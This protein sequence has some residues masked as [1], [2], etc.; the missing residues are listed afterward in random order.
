MPKFYLVTG[1]LGAGKTTFLKKFIPS[2]APMRMHIIVNEYGK[3]SVDGPLLET[4]DASLK[5]INNGSIFCSCKINDFEDALLHAIENEPECIIVEASGLADP[6]AIRSIIHSEKFKNRIDYGGAICMVDAVRFEKVYDTA[7]CTKR[8]IAASDIV[9]LNKVDKTSL[10]KVSQVESL[11][12]T[13]KPDMPIYQT[14]FGDFEM[15]WIHKLNID[16]SGDHDYAITAPDITL[17]RFLVKVDPSTS[18]AQM[19]Y[20]LNTILEDTYRVKGFVL[21][22]NKRHLIN[23]VGPMVNIEAYNDGNE[24]NLGTL[25]ILSGEGLPIR[26]SLKRGFDQYGDYFKLSK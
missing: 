20:F 10:E 11:I 6:T 14:T 2:L 21:L 23:C 8:Q 12:K 25:V 17:Q 5:Q 16:L 3:E 24:S 22:E 19:K 15:E 4:L 9:L 7:K 13:H 1:F 18:E 26:K